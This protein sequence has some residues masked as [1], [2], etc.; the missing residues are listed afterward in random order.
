[1]F[2]TKTFST[3][4]EVTDYLNDLSKAWIVELWQVFI[5]QTALNLNLVPKVNFVLFVEV[6][7][8]ISTAVKEYENAI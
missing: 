5:I 2:K 4:V 8:K 7:T 6:S 1:M 3:S